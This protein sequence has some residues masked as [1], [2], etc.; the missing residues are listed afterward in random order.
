MMALGSAVTFYEEKTD[1][2]E[3]KRRFLDAGE[4]P[5]NGVIIY[6]LL[7]YKPEAEI[8]LTILDA[9]GNEIKTFSSK[10]KDEPE[11]AEAKKEIKSNNE[12]RRIR[13]EAGL[14][15]FVWDMRYPDATKV[16][17]DLTTESSNVGPVAAP[18]RYQVQ[19]KVGD[20]TCTQSFE[21][22]QDS[23]IKA[24][25]AELTA[26]FELWLKIRDKV[27][28]THQAIN[29]LRRVRQQIKNWVEYLAESSDLKER[30][31]IGSISQAAQ[32]L[33]EKLNAIEKE[34][35]QTEAKTSSDRL[36]LPAR[37]NAKLIALT[38]IVSGADAAPPKQAYD[39]FEH[40]SQQVD[41]QLARLEA[42]IKTEVVTF[43][44]MLRVAETPAVIV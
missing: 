13:A 24:T 28:E 40:L 12:E 1:E 8:T 31:D 33:Q 9:E 26:Q 11:K 39:V 14:N 34:L 38:S 30:L 27:S 37:L 41:E 29:K 22:R 3:R 42:L 5:P 18:G 19:L 35:I 10:A 4:N 44:D 6:Y 36:R 32:A 23:R 43:N 21:L 25:P 20:Q 17:G 2:G 16:P 7:P 15:R